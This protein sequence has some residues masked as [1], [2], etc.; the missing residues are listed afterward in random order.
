MGEKITP[1]EL[2]ILIIYT[3]L[4]LYYPFMSDEAIGKIGI[5][6]EERGKRNF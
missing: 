4:L 5:K 6:L 2:G 1:N 3:M